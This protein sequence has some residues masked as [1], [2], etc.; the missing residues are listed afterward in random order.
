MTEEMEATPATLTEVSV[1]TKNK[2]KIEANSL[3]N[4]VQILKNKTVEQEKKN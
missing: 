4:E 2:L 3:K 1:S